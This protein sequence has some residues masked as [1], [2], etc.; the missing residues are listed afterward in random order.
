MARTKTELTIAVGIAAI[1]GIRA[2]CGSSE[3]PTYGETV[4]PRVRAP[5]QDTRLR[6][7]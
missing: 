1:R 5:H 2:I 4:F 6:V 7:D 3:L